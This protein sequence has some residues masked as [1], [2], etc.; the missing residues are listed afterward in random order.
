MK[1]VLIEVV[2][3]VQKDQTIFIGYLTK[4]QARQLTFSDHFPPQEGR[5]GYQ[6]PAD[7]KRA[8]AFAKYVSEKPTGF[9]TPILLNARDDCSFISHNDSGYGRLHLPVKSC[10]S[11]IDGQHRVLGLMDCK[12]TNLPI[13][14]MLFQNL[15]LD[16]EQ[17]LFITINREQKKVNMSHVWFNDRKNDELSQLV[18]KLES[19]VGSPWY[20][21]VNLN[22]VRGAK[23]AVSLDS[24]RGSL[25]E[26]FQS[27]EIKALDFN[28]KYEIATGY[29]S[30][31]SEVWP[32]AWQATKNSLIKKTMGT[33][34]LSKLGGFLIVECLDRN[35]KKLD[36]V[37]L[38]SLL[39]RASHINWMNNGEFNGI[40]GRKGA[41]VVKN[42][43]DEIIFSKVGANS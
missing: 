2:K 24:L 17:E 37:K 13:P 41:D 5:I 40:S 22:G 30:I 9:V 29:W 35:T 6:R 43:L 16:A 27:G 12:Y 36:L 19:E 15:D 33:L 4:E 32:E 34:A 42:K 1:E 11:I 18:V 7:M 31:V 21:K 28:Q 38:K 20:Q 8:K 3:N 26:L 23:R 39:S 14:F 25:I 10:L